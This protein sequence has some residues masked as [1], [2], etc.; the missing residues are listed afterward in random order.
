MY[1]LK[2]DDDSYKKFWQLMRLKKDF[3][4][5]KMMPSFYDC[6]YYTKDDEMGKILDVIESIRQKMINLTPPPMG[7]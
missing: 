6:I 7:D 4:I 5:L 3:P 2:L 1:L